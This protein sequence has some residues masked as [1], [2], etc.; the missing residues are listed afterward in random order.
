[1]TESGQ[2]P[3]AGTPE[4]WVFAGPNG[5]GKST[6]AARHLRGRVPVVNPD[7]IAKTLPPG[8]DGGAD[9]LAAGRLALD[10]RERHLTAG[11]SF[12]V[13]TT[14]TG[15]GEIALMSRAVGTGY[16]IRFY[17]VGL[18]DLALSVRRVAGRVAAGGHDVAR[19]DLF[20]R[21]ERSRANL[22]EALRLADRAFILDNSSERRRLV[23][24][25][26]EGR[27]RRVLS[28]LP[29]WVARALP[30]DLLDRDA[31]EPPP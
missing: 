12:A 27:T 5:A 25:R 15:R 31:P 6:L 21:F 17:Y 14:L 11:R 7:E 8:R 1:M 10:E 13:E 24:V 9:V 20:R 2:P 23:L 16:V 30:P 19:A 3:R 4:L 26:V 28:R 29:A 18:D 22:P